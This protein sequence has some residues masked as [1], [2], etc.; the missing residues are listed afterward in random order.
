MIIVGKT[1]WV[2]KWI[3]SP[4]FPWEIRISVDDNADEFIGAEVS[5]KDS[6]C[7]FTIVNRMGAVVA[8][9][10]HGPIPGFWQSW[11]RAPRY[12]LIKDTADKEPTI[13]ISS[14]GWKWFNRKITWDDFEDTYRYI[15]KRHTYIKSLGIDLNIDQ[16]SFRAVCEKPSSELAIHMLVAVLYFEWV[17]FA[18]GEQS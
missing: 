12:H 6:S 8:E 1:D 18:I 11:T 15:Y 10:H 5:Q 17:S 14:V 3:Y 13:T 4:G 7:D 16:R 9:C 2:G